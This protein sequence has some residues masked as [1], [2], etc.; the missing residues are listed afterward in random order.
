MAG[1]AFADSLSERI[2]KSKVVLRGNDG[3]VSHIGCK[4]RQLRLN[5]NSILIPPAESLN[6][7]GVPKIMRPWYVSVGRADVHMLKQAAERIA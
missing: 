4:G 3:N 5:V 1:K 6:G 2:E 7:E